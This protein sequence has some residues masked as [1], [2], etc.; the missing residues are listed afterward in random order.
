M[1]LYYGNTKIGSLYLGSDKI[2]EAYYGN[3]KVFGSSSDPYNPYNLPPYT[4]RCAFSSGYT[5]E[6]EGATITLVDEAN[7]VW[8][9]TRE[10][11]DS[12]FF[13]DT[14]LV[15]VLGANSS[16]IIY[17]DDTF[18]RCTNLVRVSAMDT[19]SVESL[20]GLFGFCSS[21]QALPDLPVDNVSYA[22][23]AFYSCTSVAS[24]ILS[25]YNKLSATG[26][27][28]S[29]TDTFYNCGSSTTTGAAELAQI[30]DDWK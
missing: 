9:I 25:M 10:S 24:G 1:S 16:D 7:N 23:N 8:D 3:V 18:G 4:M 26:K 13:E 19:S 29:H 20:G 14:F 5:P 27:V 15:E 11:W 17:M 2:K 22:S 21:L 6:K 30:P 12:L 28:D